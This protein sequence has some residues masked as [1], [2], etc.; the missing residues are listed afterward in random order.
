MYR[1]F[2]VNLYKCIARNGHKLLISRYLDRSMWICSIKVQ[3]SEGNK[4]YI[5]L[6]QFNDIVIENN[7]KIFYCLRIWSPNTTFSHFPTTSNN[8]HFHLFYFF[9]IPVFFSQN[10][11]SNS[12]FLPLSQKNSLSLFLLSFSCLFSFFKSGLQTLLHPTFPRPQTTFTFTFSTY[13]FFC[14][15][16]PQIL[17]SN[18]YFLPLSHCLKI[19]HLHLFVSFF[20]VFFLFKIWSPTPSSSP[21]PTASNNFHI[22]LLYF[23]FILIFS[24]LTIWS[25]A[26][27][28]SHFPTVS[29]EFTFT[30]SSP[31]FPVFFLSSK[32][33]LQI[34][35]PTAS[36]NF[37]FHTALQ[38]FSL[39]LLNILVAFYFHP[40]VFWRVSS[41]VIN[42]VVSHSCFSILLSHGQEIFLLSTQ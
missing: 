33:G 34:L 12:Y 1:F 37:H 31:F 23:F 6:S 38:S 8:F 19:I 2:W 26:F 7:W 5:L 30:F 42:N 11:V 15:F 18:S 24:P 36:N 35:L 27:T 22:H 17:A 20:P 39:A 10:L 28:S 32:S 4:I 9:V 21:F 41:S 14:L 29:K 3:L 40:P 16:P 13:Y 25:P